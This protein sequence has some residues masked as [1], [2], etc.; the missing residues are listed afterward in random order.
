M[1][2][3]LLSQKLLNV[4]NNKVWTKTLHLQKLLRL[5][6]ISVNREF[7]VERYIVA[8]TIVLV[9]Y[10]RTLLQ[11]P[12]FLWNTAVIVTG[13]IGFGC[14]VCHMLCLMA[15]SDVGDQFLMSISSSEASLRYILQKALYKTLYFLCRNYRFWML[16]LPYAVSGGVFNCWQSVLDV[17]LKQRDISQVISPW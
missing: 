3:C 17:N 10:S 7:V 5:S 13:T 15:S 6:L 8:G 11:E 9:R 12:L 2:V 1:S 4:E 16:S 14:W